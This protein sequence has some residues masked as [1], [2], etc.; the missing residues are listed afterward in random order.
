VNIKYLNLIVL[1][2]FVDFN[3][4]DVNNSMK[5]GLSRYIIGYLIYFMQFV[6][7]FIYIKWLYACVICTLLY[8]NVGTINILL[9][10]T[11]FL[12]FKTIFN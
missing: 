5:I 4:D 2:F 10:I 12:R 11:Y 7:L 9:L 1:I 8:Y 6:F 3:N